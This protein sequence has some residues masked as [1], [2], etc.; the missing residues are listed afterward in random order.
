MKH[1]IILSVLFCLSFGLPSHAASD[2][3]PLRPEFY[4]DFSTDLENLYI[5]HDPLNW[6]IRILDHPT[7]RELFDKD[8]YP[9]SLL[10]KSGAPEIEKW[11]KAVEAQSMWIPE[12]TVFGVDA[13]FIDNIDAQIKSLIYGFYFKASQ[14][15]GAPSDSKDV[16]EIRTKLL[17]SI[18]Q[19][20]V[21]NLKIWCRFR[22]PMSS[23]MV[24]QMA[25][26]SFNALKDK[27]PIPL[28][29]KITS[30]EISLNIKLSDYLPVFLIRTSLIGMGMVDLS[31]AEIDQLI[32]FVHGIAFT[33]KLSAKDS[34]LMF[35]IIP[36]TKGNFEN[37]KASPFPDRGSSEA[38]FDLISLKWNI[39][40]LV[41]Y[42]VQ[43]Q[44][45]ISTWKET[46]IG[47]ALDNLDKT[48]MLN[49]L[50]NLA[51]KIEPMGSSGQIHY[52]HD[53]QTHF[54]GHAQGFRKAP[55][56][57]SYEWP[58]ARLN[59]LHSYVIDNS[60]DI[61]TQARILMNDMNLQIDRLRAF[62]QNSQEQPQLQNWLDFYDRE[63]SALLFSAL[64]EAPSIFEQG[65]YYGL[66]N[67]YTKSKINLTSKTEDAIQLKGLNIP[68]FMFLTRVKDA[69]GAEAFLKK[70]LTS[71]QSKLWK[72]FLGKKDG[73]EVFVS[74]TLADHKIYTLK[75]DHLVSLLSDHN[76]TVDIKGDFDCHYYV[77]ENQLIFS[78]SKSLSSDF[79]N[80]K[81]ETF[82]ARL[83]DACISKMQLSPSHFGDTLDLI[84]TILQQMDAT[85]PKDI[86]PWLKGFLALIDSVSG[87]I[88]Q[89]K[90]GYLRRFE[91]NINYP[92]DQNK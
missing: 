62:S 80:A 52:W 20:K 77:W 4:Q 66:K 10:E 17:Q 19:F 30:D 2:K 53:G 65:I 23:A 72:H 18:Q 42:V 35:E 63:L 16:V 28:P 71:L 75:L 12:Q 47:K 83:D 56:I 73:P 8:H 15:I 44:Q 43:W 26:L 76:T 55:S 31:E 38:A 7:L 50:V 58:L 5:I 51:D 46:N 91:G 84:D 59:D 81:P 25:Q 9:K 87:T 90:M 92:N 78:N 70:Y 49:S 39:E 64:K 86:L 1:T 24:M 60:V 67:A 3:A 29:L 11:I 27:Y 41:Q 85:H 33:L 14:D 82:K 37:M 22:S 54:E 34:T 32:K 13:I 21:S 48:G 89:D 6:I 88:H 36:D 61:N 79:F 69:R 40:H 68:N 74:E 57:N 45:I